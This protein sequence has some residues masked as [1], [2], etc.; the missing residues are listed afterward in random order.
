MSDQRRP[1]LQQQ[2]PQPSARPPA[3][4]PSKERSSLFDDIPEHQIGEAP[5]TCPAHLAGANGRTLGFGRTV[6][7]EKEAL[8][9]I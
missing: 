3:P 7:S 8:V 4:P 2:Q 5:H 9:I 6:V 1:H